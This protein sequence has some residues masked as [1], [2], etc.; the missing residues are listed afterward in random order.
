MRNTSYTWKKIVESGSFHMQTVARIYGATGNDSAA[1]SGSDS[2]GS[3]RQ[4]VTITAPEISHGL[5]NGNVLSI[6]NCVSATLKFTLMTTDT[7]PKSAKIV[8]LSRVTDVNADVQEYSE[9]LEFGTYWIDRRTYN[10]DLIDLE[11]YDAMKMANQPYDHSKDTSH[12]WP[13]TVSDVVTRAASQ[14][15]VSLDSRTTD[16]F[17]QTGIWNQ[18]VISYPPDDDTLIKILGY[19]GGIFGGNWYITQDNKLRYIPLVSAPIGGY[20][21]SEAGERIKAENND[22]V[23]WGDTLV[24]TETE[25]GHITSQIDERIMAENGDYVVYDDLGSAYRVYNPGGSGCVVVPVI[26]GS[27]TTA[28]LVWVSKVTVSR[29]NENSYTFGDDGGFE[30]IVSNN[31][32]ANKSLVEALYH[33]IKGTIY[34]PYNATNAVYDPAAELG[35]WVIAGDIVR[36]TMFAENYKLDIGFSADISAPGED[37]LDSEY[38]FVTIEER[39]TQSIEKTAAELKK[40]TKD[41]VENATNIIT[42]AND[43]SIRFMYDDQQRLHEIA[44]LDNYGITNAKKVWRWNMGGLGYST[45]GYNG[46]FGLAITQDGSIVADYINT[47]TLDAN[48]VNV[49]N[50]NA[51]N[52]T[53]GTFQADDNVVK[54]KGLLR[55]DDNNNYWNL[56]SGEFQI[57]GSDDNV[58]AIKV[59]VDS[60]T[61]KSTATINASK[62]TAG[63]L[64]AQ[65]I[66]ISNLDKNEA[67]KSQIVSIAD[68][69]I[70]TAELE[71]T[72][73]NDNYWNLATGEFKV[74]AKSANAN[75]IYVKDGNVTINADNITTGTLKAV[76]IKNR[77]NRNN[78]WNLTTGEFK[79][80]G[81]DSTDYAIRVTRSGTEPNYTWT[82]QINADKITTGTFIAGPSAVKIKGL[83]RTGDDNNTNYWNLSTGEFQIKGSTDDAPAIKVTADSEGKT[84]AQINANKITTGTLTAIEIRDVEKKNY[85]N[86]SDGTLRIGNS[87]TDYAIMVDSTGRAKINASKITAGSLTIAKFN[88]DARGELVSSDEVTQLLPGAIKTMKIESQD[89]ACYWNLATGAF[90]LSTRAS[91]S[92]TDETDGIDTNYD[93]IKVSV[94]EDGDGKYSIDKVEINASKITTGTLSVDRIANIPASKLNSATLNNNWSID[95]K[96]GTMNIGDISADNIT[97]GKISTGLLDVNNIVVNGRA[98]INELVSDGTIKVRTVNAVGVSADYITAGTLKLGGSKANKVGI[99]MEDGSGNVIG[100]WNKDGLQINKGGFQLLDQQSEF[101]STAQNGKCMAL[102]AGAL[103]IVDPNN[104][105]TIYG[106]IGYYGNSSATASK[107]G[108]QIKSGTKTSAGTL[109]IGGKVT[110][111]NLRAVKTSTSGS[112]AKGITQYVHI[113]KGTSRTLHFVNGI[114]TY[115]S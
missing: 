21:M 24:I 26:V 112:G 30:L 16:Y 8:I 6:G 20:I 90:K 2:R 29:D 62:I 95:F 89:G 99:V 57:K 83:L 46:P 3:Y 27:V 67:N 105:N 37:E 58:A 111:E 109:F 12:E 52:I 114:L 104:L 40:E 86:L 41:A 17:V 39:V 56:N 72:T 102:R 33:R 88:T 96:N 107:R 35:D 74:K 9:W 54:I 42:G 43:G 32:Y 68:G 98:K 113:Q 81:S 66:T 108:V 53:T 70:K 31:P 22:L 110:I 77:D 106:S 28:N 34:Q 18:R 100:E 10:D 19:I 85:W 78:Y 45:N 49:A 60:N 4:Y 50:L 7:I 47:G 84:S 36:G 11:C 75:A 44:I 101:V 82:T 48:A 91:T 51:S 15:G 55:S 63:T 65:N 23:V 38:P 73:G 71:S 64:N 13:K 87:N 1:T 69:V 79:L 76:E 80:G 92:Q 61:K 94:K 115:Y 97:S 25:R 14:I 103:Q 59:T 5:L 93:A